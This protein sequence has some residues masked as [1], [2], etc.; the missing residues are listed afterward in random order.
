[1]L[2]TAQPPQLPQPPASVSNP[3]RFSASSFSVQELA[4]LALA[5]KSGRISNVDISQFENSA[6]K[7]YLRDTKVALMVC[8][9]CHGG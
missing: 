8:K 9:G 7:S 4:K 2:Y 3:A 1:M 5:M 6:F